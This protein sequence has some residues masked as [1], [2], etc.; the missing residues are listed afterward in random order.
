MT[1]DLVNTGPRGIALVDASGKLLDFISYE[2]TVDAIDGPA[3][4]SLSIDVGV[5]QNGSGSKDQS[6]Q[7]VNK[8]DAATTCEKTDFEW[9]LQ[10]R[11]KGKPNIGQTINCSSDDTIPPNVSPTVSP[12]IS[13]PKQAQVWI[14]EFHY[15]SRVID[16]CTKSAVF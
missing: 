4:G 13:P 10:P 7:L 5:R 6:I 1:N 12:T 14:N 3:E 11:S 9:K 16:T 8:V 15:V 2:G